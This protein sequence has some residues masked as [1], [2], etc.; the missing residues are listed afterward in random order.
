MEIR[1]VQ[2]PSCIKTESEG[3]SYSKDGQVP[4]GSQAPGQRLPVEKHPL[5][6]R[7]WQSKVR[8]SRHPLGRQAEEQRSDSK[9]D[10]TLLS[11]GGDIGGEETATFGRSAGAAISRGDR[12]RSRLLKRLPIWNRK[13]SIFHP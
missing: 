2:S 4:S 11:Q 9:R 6:M 3:Q 5:R 12:D 10:R 1:K 8:E 7:S 13:A